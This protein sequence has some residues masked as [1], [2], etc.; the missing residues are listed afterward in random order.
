MLTNTLQIGRV[1]RRTLYVHFL[2]TFSEARFPAAHA[3]KSLCSASSGA[4]PKT[5]LEAR[6]GTR[7]REFGANNRRQFFGTRQ[8]FEASAM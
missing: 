3:P 4:R 7:E 8:S 1:R 2:G 5:K 6:G